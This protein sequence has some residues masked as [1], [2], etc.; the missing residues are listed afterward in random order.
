MQKNV[1]RSQSRWLL[2]AAVVDVLPVVIVVVMLAVVLV[3]FFPE[4]LIG[5]VGGGRCNGA[6]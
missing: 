6:R 3:E 4:R 2:A 5:M 1:C